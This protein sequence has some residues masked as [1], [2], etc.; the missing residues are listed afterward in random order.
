MKK[1]NAA[2]GIVVRC[3]RAEQG[4]SAG[5]LAAKAGITPGKLARMERGDCN[6]EGCTLEKVAKALGLAS[7]LDLW[8]QA[9]LAEVVES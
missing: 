8:F 7:V 4:T 5:M 6:P 9:R 2:L 3:L 1:R